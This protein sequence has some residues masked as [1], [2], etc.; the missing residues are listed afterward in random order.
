[1]GMLPGG[2]IRQTVCGAAALVFV[3]AWSICAKAQSPNNGSPQAA[4]RTANV[5][6]TNSDDQAN[7]EDTQIFTL[8]STATANLLTGKLLSAGRSPLHWGKL[9]V[10]SFSANQYYDLNYSFSPVGPSNAQATDVQALLVYSVQK[11]R[12]GFD[13]QY[14]PAVWITGSGTEADLDNQ[15][16]DIHTSFQLKPHWSMVLSDS[17]TSLPY[18]GAI[19]GNATIVSDPSSGALLRNPFLASG[20]RTS[21]NQFRLGNDYRISAR[22]TLTF[23]FSQSYTRSTAI[24]AGTPVVG[25]GSN[26]SFS[27]GNQFSADMGLT[28]LISE[29]SSIGLVYDYNYL[30]FGPIAASSQRHSITPTYSRLF[31]DG[32]RFSAGVGYTIS[33]PGDNPGL[34]AGAGRQQSYMGN[35]ALQKAFR[36]SSLTLSW[37]RN[38]DFAGVI[39][40]GLN[41]RF[42]LTASQTI[43]RRLSG[44]VS[45]GYL[46]Q[47]VTNAPQV[48]SWV[49]DASISYALTA[50][51]SLTAAYHY[52]G[53]SGLPLLPYEARQ[54]ISFGP[55]WSWSPG[56]THE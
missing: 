17:F 37:A 4:S 44:T 15:L 56:R 55:T 21:D 28:H 1:M 19:S 36:R 47:Q 7:G 14:R 53:E 51:W 30:T 27:S 40:S 35:A 2:Q 13:A 12:F 8:P 29:R 33:L 5:G 3:A 49:G 16:G 18:R 31:G 32:L 9:S 54:L 52:L 20:G 39:S 23:G 25:P 46:R 41:D 34:L 10:F 38:S 26:G 11:S 42:E 48:H 43:L 22:N 6:V 50:R 45:A 24:A